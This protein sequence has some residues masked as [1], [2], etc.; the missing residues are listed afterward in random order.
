VYQTISTRSRL[1]STKPLTHFSFQFPIVWSSTD[2][3]R[4][5]RTSSYAPKWAQEGST[6]I[7]LPIFKLVARTGWTVIVTRRPLYLQEG[8]PV[9]T[10]QEAGWASGPGWMFPEK[11]HHPPCFQPRTVLAPASHHTVYNIPA[12]YNDCADTGSSQR[13][14]ITQERNVSA[15][16]CRKEPPPCACVCVCVCVCVSDCGWKW[17]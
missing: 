2:E 10:Q 13:T 3:S 7:A 16:Q 11:S 1:P 4:N 12:R 8:N 15:W 6:G 14:V 17:L 5:V 9:P